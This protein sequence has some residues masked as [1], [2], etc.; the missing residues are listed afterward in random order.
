MSFLPSRILTPTVTIDNYPSF[1][2]GGQTIGMSRL[3]RHYRRR[4]GRAGIYWQPV[5]F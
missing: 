2:A 5:S 4:S 1:V 3:E